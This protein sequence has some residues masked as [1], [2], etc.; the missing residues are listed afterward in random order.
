MLRDFGAAGQKSSAATSVQ[1]VLPLDVKGSDALVTTLKTLVPWAKC[2]KLD[3]FADEPF[4][5]TGIGK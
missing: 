3:T 5:D 4:A 1:C 2:R